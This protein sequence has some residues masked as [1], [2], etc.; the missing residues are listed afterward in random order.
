MLSVIKTAII[1]IIISFISGVLLDNYKNLAPKISCTMGKCVPIKMNNKKIRAYILKV[2]NISNKTLHDLTVNVQGHHNDLK[3]DDAQITGGLKFDI[4]GE[5]NNFNVSIPFLSKNDEFSVKVFV[6]DVQGEHS[7]PVITLRSP[8]N[9]KKIGHGEGNGLFPVL[10][11]TSQKICNLFSNKEEKNRRNIQKSKI[12][13]SILNKKTLIT[14]AFIISLLCIVFLGKGLYKSISGITQDESIQSDT[15][16]KS[17]SVDT[18]SNETA[19]NSSGNTSN[20]GKSESS[21]TKSSSKDGSSN[22]VKTQVSSSYDSGQ[23]SNN[24]DDKNSEENKN[25]STSNTDVNKQTA[26]EKNKDSSS[27]TSN[28]NTNK[29]SADEKAN[30]STKTSTST[31]TTGNTK[32]NQSN[33]SSSSDTNVNY[34]S[35]KQQ[36]SNSESSGN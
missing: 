30:E 24:K 13:K 36:V 14:T 4:C 28:N 3:M 11:D 2:K 18:P 17:N 20:N 33:T 26:D 15:E 35:E 8:E 34:P 16:Q 1:T 5:Y 7:K 29:Q 27:S 9:F 25:T 19:K 32:V 10:S 22:E 23:T 31:N 6:D 21:S 12:E